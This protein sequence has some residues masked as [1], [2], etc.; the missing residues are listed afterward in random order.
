MSGERLN[1]DWGTPLAEWVAQI[2]NELPRDGVFL[3][4]AVGAG[5]EG[6]LLEGLELDDFVCRC[7]VSLLK[8]GAIPARAGTLVPLPD[9]QGSHSTVAKQIVADWR[10]GKVQADYDGL[11]FVLSET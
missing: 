2:A 1:K 7:I 6:Y 5:A 9:Y 10:N 11:W 8:A 4:Q 3:H